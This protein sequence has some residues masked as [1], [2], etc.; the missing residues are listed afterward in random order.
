MARFRNAALGAKDKPGDGRV[1][2]MSSSRACLCVLVLGL[3]SA[4]P[5][6]PPASGFLHPLPVTARPLHERL[7]QAGV[8]AVGHVA[9]VQPDRFLVA[10]FGDLRGQPGERFFVKR[11]RATS[12]ALAADEWGIWLLRGARS[13]Y[14]NVDTPREFLRVES[15]ADATRWL[16]ALRDLLATAEQP[17]ALQLVYLNWLD[18]DF[19]PLYPVAASALLQPRAGLPPLSE[20]QV[21]ERA[22]AALD[23]ER[24]RASRRACA[25]IAASHPTGALALLRG[26]PGSGRQASEPEV[27]EIALQAGFAAQ[28]SSPLEHTV[29]RALHH[30]HYEIRLSALRAAKLLWTP[31]ISETVQRLAAED[32]NESVRTLAAQTAGES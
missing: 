27:L 26:L 5:A 13:P 30:E 4:A 24:P 7:A 25:Q 11:S 23:A 31:A 18:E 9:A 22:R 6:E 32:P 20:S 2:E 8:I 12:P 29:L 17:E 15:R 19:E 16:V 3:A 10:T 1:Y 14:V 21:R 28:L